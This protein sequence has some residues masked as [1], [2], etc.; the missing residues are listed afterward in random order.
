MSEPPARRTRSSSASTC[1]RPDQ[2]GEGSRARGQRQPAVEQADQRERQPDHEHGQGTDVGPGPCHRPQRAALRAG[3][4]Q[5]GGD[6]GARDQ[7][8]RAQHEAG[9]GAGHQQHQLMDRPVPGADHGQEA[10][11][12]KAERPDRRGQDVL[13]VQKPRRAVADHAQPAGRVVGRQQGPRAEDHQA[14]DDHGTEI[15]EQ[16]RGHHPAPAAGHQHHG[17]GRDGEDQEAAEI[18]RA[19][20]QQLDQAGCYALVGVRCRRRPGPRAEQPLGR[21]AGAE[22]QAERQRGRKPAPPLWPSCSSPA[23]KAA[24]TSAKAASFSARPARRRS[25]SVERHA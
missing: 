25:T 22:H 9:A 4:E 20:E 15:G 2:D 16:D 8:R 1:G 24:G 11:G 23:R 12:Q 3:V 17:Q 19:G 6:V 10:A 5:V 18:A 14:D 13:A 21:E 7:G